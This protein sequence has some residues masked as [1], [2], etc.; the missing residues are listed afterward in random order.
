MV[1]LGFTIKGIHVLSSMM[2]IWGPIIMLVNIW[3]IYQIVKHDDVGN[4]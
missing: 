2:T 1:G 4:F 3:L